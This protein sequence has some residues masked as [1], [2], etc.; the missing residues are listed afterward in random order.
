MESKVRWFALTKENRA[1]AAGVAT[2]W[3]L[4]F[5]GSP[6]L[7]IASSAAQVTKQVHYR[8]AAVSSQPVR[9]VQLWER[10]QSQNISKDTLDR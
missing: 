3:R 4:I 6:S 10:S 5:P 2:V 1:A 7:M 9:L 8:Y